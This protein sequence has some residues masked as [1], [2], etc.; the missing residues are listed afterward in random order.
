M[1]SRLKHWFRALAVL[2]CVSGGATPLVHAS[3][4]PAAPGPTTRPVPPAPG[5]TTTRPPPPAPGPTTTRPVEIIP[6]GRGG[7]AYGLNFPQEGGICIP[8][9]SIPPGDDAAV[10]RYCRAELKKYYPDLDN[11]G[12][13]GRGL[14]TCHEE[15]VRMECGPN[16]QTVLMMNCY[17]VS[18]SGHAQDPPDFHPPKGGVG[19]PGGG[20]IGGT[21][22]LRCVRDGDPVTIPTVPR[23]TPA[24]A[25]PPARPTGRPPVTPPPARPPPVRPPPVRP[26]VVRPPVRP[27]EPPVR[28]PIP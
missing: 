13:D 3:D 26:P 7:G 21:R 23:P 24:P 28:P 14:W 15:L 2:L 8:A 11:Q 17:K 1:S 12:P 16:G 9:S 18:R 5:P 25:R 20:V 22:L 10:R 6:P 27:V 19:V 4:T